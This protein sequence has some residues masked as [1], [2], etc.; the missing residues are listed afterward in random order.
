V[1]DITANTAIHQLAHD[2]LD[3]PFLIGQQAV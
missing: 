1:T 3:L 2:C